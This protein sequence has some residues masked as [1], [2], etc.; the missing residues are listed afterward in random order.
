LL[1]C[2]WSSD[3]P[4]NITYSSVV[5]RDGIRLAFLV[6]ALNDLEILGG[7][8]G[9]TNLQAEAKEGAYYLWT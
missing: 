1:C 8:I 2:R 4:S 9:N 5:A 3:P 6:A 7:D